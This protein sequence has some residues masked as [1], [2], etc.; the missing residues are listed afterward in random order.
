VATILLPKVSGRID[1]LAFDG[2]RQ[3]LF[4]AALGNNTLEVIDTAKGVHQRSV[5][6]FHEPQGLAVIADL[7]AVA[8]ANGGTGTRQLVDAESL[9]TRWTVHV[10]G[11]ADYV[12]FDAVT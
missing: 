9:Q 6:G 5:P 1:H 11:D 2:T 10:G 3:R 7:N 8:V 12:R 4:V